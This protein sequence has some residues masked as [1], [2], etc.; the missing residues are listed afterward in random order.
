MID[1]N[2]FKYRRREI[3]NILGRMF[4]FVSANVADG[5]CSTFANVNN[6]EFLTTPV[7]TEG[8]VIFFV[9]PC[10]NAKIF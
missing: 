3:S 7:R 4:A 6:P 5:I 9:N 2:Q 10:L 8:W 1:N